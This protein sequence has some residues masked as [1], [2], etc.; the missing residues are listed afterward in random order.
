MA[1]I[2]QMQQKLADNHVSQF[3]MK[4]ART[5]LAHAATFAAEL[6][7]LQLKGFEQATQGIDEAARLAKEGLAATQE[8]SAA[9]QKIASDA[10]AEVTKRADA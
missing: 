8:L 3:W 10:V 7:K 2:T 5:Q 9:W 1:P 4:A 6:E